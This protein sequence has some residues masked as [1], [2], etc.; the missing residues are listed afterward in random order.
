MSSPEFNTTETAFGTTLG[1]E[2]CSEEPSSP[3]L[4]DAC[5][6]QLDELPWALSD[7][8]FDQT[9]ARYDLPNDF[10]R[11]SS[12]VSTT[13]FAT[14][15]NADTNS[16]QI[17]SPDCVSRRQAMPTS[18]SCSDRSPDSPSCNPEYESSSR[19]S[20]DAGT[21]PKRQMGKPGQSKLDP[22]TRSASGA[23]TEGQ[24]TTRIPHNMVERKYRE[25]LNAQLKR[26]RR[27]V[28]AL[29]Q[30]SDG[31][32]TGQP[33]LSKSMVIAAAIDHIEMV[34]QERD[35]LQ[36]ENDV[37]SEYR[38]ENISSEGRRG[39]KKRPVDLAFGSAAV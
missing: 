19:V 13:A 28:P 38:K 27:A 29:L 25:G 2:L 26:L 14:A 21:V 35:M 7:T 15:V 37:I 33:K 39:S 3:Y 9:V 32:G 6:S 20:A 4:V 16:I 10:L 12:E 1:N 8:F 23:S 36:K 24:C 17:L 34:T 11:R 30:T 5:T 18:S 31:D 22:I